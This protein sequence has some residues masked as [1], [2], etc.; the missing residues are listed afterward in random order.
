MFSK[1]NLMGRIVQ[2]LGV[3][4]PIFGVGLGLLGMS[5]NDMYSRNEA[6]SSLAVS[7][8]IAQAQAFDYAVIGLFI[9]L[10]VYAFG[11][12]IRAQ[13]SIARDARRTANAMERM[14]FQQLSLIHI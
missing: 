11:G 9:G 5:I 13:V 12:I 6:F 1:L 7:T 8:S 14:A 3:L 4:I 10:L 2:I